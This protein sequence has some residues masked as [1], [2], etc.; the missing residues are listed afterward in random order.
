MSTGMYGDSEH[1]TAV[2]RAAALDHAA[3][4]L[5]EIS[6]QLSNKLPVP[7]ASNKSAG[8]CE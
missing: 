4:A 1:K 6:D 8:V 2:Q 3:P 7:R 5:D